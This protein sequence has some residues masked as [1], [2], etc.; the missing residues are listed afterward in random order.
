MSRHLLNSSPIVEQ[1]SV[2]EAGIVLNGIVNALL[3]W[4]IPRQLE[5]DVYRK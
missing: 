3:D 4:P 2:E 1:D 5:T